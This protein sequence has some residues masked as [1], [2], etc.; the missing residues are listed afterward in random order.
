MLLN[1]LN[2]F[3]IFAILLGLLW[4]I[5]RKAKNKNFAGLKRSEHIKVVDEG[6]QMGF[7]QKISIVKIEKEYFAFTYGQS[8]VAFQRLEAIQI[9]DQQSKWEKE[10]MGEEH[11]ESFKALG[12][13][14]KNEK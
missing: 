6:I 13:M 10:I 8:G 14:L 1:F 5:V 11:Q 12:E 9:E 3:I 7:G 2:I 4:F